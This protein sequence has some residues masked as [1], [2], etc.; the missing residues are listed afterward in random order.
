MNGYFADM[1]RV[2][3]EQ[4]HPNPD[5]HDGMETLIQQRRDNVRGLADQ[6][7]TSEAGIEVAR[8]ITR[9]LSPSG[10][11]DAAHRK[12]RS[13]QQSAARDPRSL[14]RTYGGFIKNVLPQ[15]AASI[16]AR[17]QPAR[18]GTTRSLTGFTPRAETTGMDDADVQD[19]SQIVDWNPVNQALFDERFDWGTR[20]PST[21][22]V[23]YAQED[24]WVLG[25]L[26]DIIRRT[27]R[28]AP[29]R[30]QAAV[31]EIDFIQIAKDVTVPRFQV[32]RPAPLTSEEAE[33]RRSGQ[34]PLG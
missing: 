21:R 30:S 34:R 11:T 33:R 19:E 15:L 14:R 23:L 6:V 10:G 5:F 1:Q 24:L 18:S 8:G 20:P 27:N 7:G 26:I 31:K 13:R 17:W 22:E 12:G 2:R 28:D 29:T 4:R 32:L 16:G 9:G 3:G 25:T